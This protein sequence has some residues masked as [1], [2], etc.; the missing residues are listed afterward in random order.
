MASWRLHLLS[1]FHG[2]PAIISWPEFQLK[3]S[4]QLVLSSEYLLTVW[5]SLSSPYFLLHLCWWHTGLLVVM[6][7]P[8]LLICGATDIFH[9]FFLLIWSVGFSFSIS[10]AFF[11]LRGMQGDSKTLPPLPSSQNSKRVFLNLSGQVEN[12]WGWNKAKSYT[13]ARSDN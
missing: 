5:G 13:H 11:F 7:Y 9:L 6:I 3:C 4:H 1:T 8:Y 10:V 2:T 12:L